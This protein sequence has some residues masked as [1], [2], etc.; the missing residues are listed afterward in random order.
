MVG[1]SLRRKSSDMGMRNQSTISRG[2]GSPAEASTLRRL[3]MPSARYCRTKDEQ[4]II[5]GLVLEQF[6][7]AYAPGT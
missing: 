6:E 7:A 4:R 3:K 5:E 1:E 2:L